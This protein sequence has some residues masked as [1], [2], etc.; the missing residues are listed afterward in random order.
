MQ[1][2]DDPVII[3][4]VLGSLCRARQP[5]GWACASDLPPVEWN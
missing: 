1:I 4:L 3:D 5:T 2:N